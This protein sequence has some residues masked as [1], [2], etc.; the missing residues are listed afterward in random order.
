MSRFALELAAAL[1]FAIPIG[2]VL[3]AGGAR[4]GGDIGGL[5]GVVA[6]SMVGALIGLV[7]A[8]RAIRRYA[9]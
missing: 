3:G 8:R 9:Q 5:A 2:Y 4:L 7:V 6:A 1:G